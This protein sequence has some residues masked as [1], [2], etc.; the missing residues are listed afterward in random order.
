[1]A[2]DMDSDIVSSVL[3]LER[4][5]L[6]EYHS[7]YGR[8]AAP[9]RPSAKSVAQQHDC[10]LIKRAQKVK[11]RT[12]AGHARVASACMRRRGKARRQA[13]LS[14]CSQR[15]AKVPDDKI[16]LLYRLAGHAGG[17]AKR[18]LGMTASVVNRQREI[19]PFKH[20][21]GLEEK[22]EEMLAYKWKYFRY[23]LNVGAAG[24]HF[25]YTA[26]LDRG[27]P[28][29]DTAAESSAKQKLLREALTATSGLL[30]L[31]YRDELASSG[32]SFR[33]IRLTW[34][35]VLINLDQSALA[36]D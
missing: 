25:M 2:S 9:K 18:Y 28:S 6:E 13:W 20:F 7:V 33:P 12:S 3:D 34:S 32:D 24:L 16:M 17:Y 27:L 5:A 1:M 4:L 14:F 8:W 31:V 22:K 15:H 26:N 11:H 36:I 21:S 30:P 23:F 19:Y 29:T 35:T 10:A